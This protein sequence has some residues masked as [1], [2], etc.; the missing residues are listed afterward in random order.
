MSK[1]TAAKAVARWEHDT[2]QW[3][4]DTWADLALDLHFDRERK[5]RPYG[6]RAR[7]VFARRLG[8]RLARVSAGSARCASIPAR[9]S[10]STMKRHPAVPSRANAHPFFPKVARNER[11]CSRVTGAI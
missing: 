1:G 10:S 2:R 6:V 8:P 7:S 5:T 3:A 9:S 4:M 11:T